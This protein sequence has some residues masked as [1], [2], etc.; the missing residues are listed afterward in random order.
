MSQNRD[1]G[2]PAFSRARHGVPAKTGLQGLYSPRCPKARHL[3]HPS[4][5]VV[6]TSSGTW[7]TR[8]KQLQILRLAALAQ[9]DSSYL[10]NLQLYNKLTFVQRADKIETK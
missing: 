3:G 1:M 6:L 9:D 10:T 8:Q 2:H 4:S 5:V 7:G